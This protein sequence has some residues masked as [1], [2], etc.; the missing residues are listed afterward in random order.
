ME[1]VDSSMDVLAVNSVVD[2]TGNEETANDT[3]DC[4]DIENG[5]ETAKDEDVRRNAESA[6]SA[7][8]SADAT[9][10]INDIIDSM[11]QSVKG[12]STDCES[13]ADSSN[14]E[15]YLEAMTPDGHDYYL[16]LG[17][18]PRR[19][20]A[21]RLSRILARQ[22]LLRRLAQEIEA[23][24][25]C[26]W[27]RAAGFPQYAQ[28]YE[29]S[30]FPIDISSVKRDHDFLDRD[31]VE[32]LCR[33][34]NTL[35]K[36]ASMKLDVSHPKKKGDDSDED[37]PLAISKRWTFEWSSRRWSRLHDFLL[38]STDESSPTGQ[39]EGLLHSTV[40]SE[41]L[42]TDLSEQEITEISSLHSE[43]SAS[44]LPDSLSM[45]SLSASYQP[46][47]DLSHYNSLPLKSSRHGQGGRS[48][49]KEF[50]RRMELMRTWGPS[51]KR[52]SSHRRPPLVISGP[53]LHG[54]EPHA[55]HML[56]CTPISQ[57]EHS[58]QQTD[59]ETSPVSPT[60]DCKDQ[61]TVSVSPSTE[62][63]A[64]VG[65]ECRKHLTGSKRSS[66]YLE[67]MELPSQG[68]RTEGQSQFGRNQFRS[69]E[70]LLVHIP[71]DHKPGTFPKALSI[72]SLVPSPDDGKNGLQTHAQTSPSSNGL[73]GPWSGKPLSKPPCPGA[74]RGS[75][76]SVYDNVPGSHL[77]ASTGD[78]LDFE[79]EDNL[80][81]HLDDIIQHVSGLQQIV[82][83][84]SRSVLP[85]D[86][87]GEG[88][89]EGEGRTTPSEG[90]RD[91]VSLNDTDSTGTSRERRDSGVG[92]SL[93]RPRLRWPSFRTS[94]H[95]NQPASSLQISSQSAGQ[96][97]LLQKFSLLRLTAI[98]EKYSMSNKHGW[99]W[100]VPK[101]M[102]RMKVPDYKEKSVFGVPLIIH[103]QRCGFPL[104]L[105][106]QQALC[107]LRTHCLDQVGLFRKSGVK[108]RIQALRQQCELS[109]DSVSYEDQ[110]AY[111]V[112]DMVKQFFRD[113]PEPL[114]TSKLGETFLH[115]YQYVPKEQR[116]QAVRAAILLM[117]DESREVLQTL[118]Y[119]LRDV[120][121]LV[122]E[123]QMT[124]MNLAVCLGPSL[125]HLS[126]L[127]NEM[128]SPR[129]IQ[130]K[131]TTGR[132]DQKDLNENL[133]AT[134][135]LSHMI[136][137]CHR[138]FQIPE[139]MVTQS[140]NSYMEAELMVPPLEELCKAHM[141]EVDEDEE[142]EEEEGSYHAHI[143]KLVQNLLEEAKDK[144]KGWVS[145]ST[146][147][148]TELAVKKV[149]DGNPLRRWR[150]CVEVSAAP[151]EV[152]QRL[153]RE[154]P[155][156]QA[157][158]QQEKVL[159]TL[160]KQTDVYQYSCHNMAP[161]PS[162]DY[163]VLRS[164][165]TDLC[166]GSCALVC[167]SVEHDDSPRMGAVRGV[168]L[169]SQ[170]LLEPCGTGR[171]RLTHISRVDLRGRSPEW[172]NKAFGDMCV[173]EAQRIRSSFHPPDPMSPEL[174][175]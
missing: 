47:R 89:E 61:S 57:L 18:T 123:N 7:E 14:E 19:R 161:V 82:D 49:A 33:R 148:N 55:L 74:P 143:E 44:A 75:R 77:Y 88:E 72:E 86:E 34:L 9:D 23:K 155:L 170:Y 130:R 73:G 13:D 156:W 154:R 124:P 103:V 71:K 147:D 53:V 150:V 169:E 4:A 63:M 151:T 91:G 99:T 60:S 134:Q 101:F 67:D 126:I 152:L 58:L 25:A 56:Q 36:C 136:N 140:R 93:T 87:P 133:A 38:D 102:K 141:E 95:L 66:M 117:P 45:A 129:S 12:E 62:A 167:V 41:S 3:L 159:E 160:D 132:P 51:T 8:H 92:A 164:W 69:Y 98:M 52:K 115:I 172:Y 139:E 54:E 11:D 50:L 5:I 48:K 78:L 97:S 162:C 145:R 128:L 119:F 94:D 22:Q 90:E 131:Y 112:A 163:V 114:L 29:D 104:P 70:N 32:P 1:A 85:E 30:Q 59:G 149:G 39:G 142:E 64:P 137:E 68:K 166:K 174:K 122:E 42:L 27:L 168:V 135:G 165:R 118:L 81:P 17:K 171:T 83:H 31:L 116:L 24:E 120:I 84:W 100:S 6:D 28:L 111:D 175:T 107:H 138:L 109:P 153:L 37:D 79:K 110:S 46:P 15:T 144:S 173:N 157:E 21:L 20:S 121:S 76:V 26:D 108:S 105:C 158:L 106:L 146:S 127:K 96:L 113:L 35:N 125:F 16:R 65:K 43:D 2:A 40:S 10:G 80:F